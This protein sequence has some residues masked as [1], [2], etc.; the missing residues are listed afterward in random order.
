LKLGLSVLA[1]RYKAP[2]WAAELGLGVPGGMKNAS[3]G[4]KEAF[5][6]EG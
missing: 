1:G 3:F 2:H 6:K 4:M 5:L